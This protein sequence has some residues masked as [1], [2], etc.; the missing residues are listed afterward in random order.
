MVSV[1]PE[2][3]NPFQRQRTAKKRKGIAS[4]YTLFCEQA[5]AQTS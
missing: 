2:D 5:C 4:A 1:F 3:L